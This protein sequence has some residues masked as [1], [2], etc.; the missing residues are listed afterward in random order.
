MLTSSLAIQFLC[1][2]GAGQNTPGP[3]APEAKAVAFLSR[4]VPRWSR[5]N[6]CFSCH[7]NGDAA[8]ALF[9]AAREGQHVPEDA[10]ADTTAWL[11]KPQA[12]D[13][14]GGDG[15]FS[16]KRLA[17]VSFTA[18]LATAISTQWIKDK[19]ALLQAADR[20]VLDQGADGSWRIEG[21]DATGSP[22]TYGRPLATF[23]ARESLATAEPARFRAAIDRADTWLLKREVQPVTDASIS[24]LAFAVA[25]RRP[26]ASRQD[27]C[28]ELLARVQDKGGGWGPDAFSPPE[29]FDTALCLL[30]LARCEPTNPLR[31]MIARGRKF[32]I[33]DQLDDGSWT[34]TTR[35]PGSLSYAQRISTTGWATT[36]LLATAA[37][38]QP[39]RSDTKR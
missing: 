7:N 2:V 29:P 17:R 9:R 32:L 1:L 26:P 11:V 14:N 34:E 35:P 22:A 37:L 12:W 30:A 10:L 3:G 23:L 8:R 20:L 6:H 13:H 16:D 27:R 24:L 31:D 15:P 38:R 21:E 36:A 33:A 25:T 28:L 4:E 5:K 18:T 19:K 39:A